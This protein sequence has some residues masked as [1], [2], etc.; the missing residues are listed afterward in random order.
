M[1]SRT[2]LGLLL[3]VALARPVAAQTE[4]G[5]A[6]E[7]VA[8]LS[9]PLHVARAITYQ[10]GESLEPFRAI[11]ELIR[12]SMTRPSLR[13]LLDHQL[14]KMLTPLASEE[15]RLFAARNLAIVGGDRSL[16]EVARLLNDEATVSLACL[17]L[18][19]YPR[20][21]ADEALRSALANTQGKARV[22][23]I[24][25][26][27]DRRDPGSI[28]VLSDLAGDSDPAV[29][30][31]AVVAL[32]KIGNPQSRKALDTLFQGDAHLESVRTLARLRTALQLADEGHRDAVPALEALLTPSTP[33]YVRRSALAALLKADQKGAPMRI[34]EVLRGHEAA[35]KPVAI[36]AVRDLRAKDASANFGGTVLPQ[37]PPEQQVWMIE[38]LAIRKDPAACDAIINALATSKDTNVRQSAAQA[39]G[40]IGEPT[41][42]RPLAKAL[43]ATTNSDEARVIVGSV[44]ALRE[45]KATDQAVLAEIKAAEDPARALLVSSLA[46]RRSPEVIAALFDEIDGSD[47]AS[48]KAA[49]RVMAKSVTSE[50][51][52]KLLT[53]Y[54]RL[55]NEKLQSEVETFIE[56]AVL[57]VDDPKVR[58]ESVRAVLAQTFQTPGRAGLV[59]LL[60]LCG[61]THSLNVAKRCL[62]DPEKP[63]RDSAVSALA[64][65][66]DAS[67]WDALFGVQ[68]LPREPRYRGIA[69]RGLVRLVSEQNAKPDAVLVERYRQLLEAARDENERKLVLGALGGAASPET[70]KLAV[71]ALN[72]PRVR[73]EAEAAIKRISEAI[74]DKHPEEVKLALDRL[75]RKR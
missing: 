33:I 7:T 9:L 8:E 64:E 18:S 61:D 37:L 20:G 23:I 55:R 41:F 51:L 67:A 29:A 27:G 13:K 65:W 52:F 70:L 56:Q 1:K 30:E 4:P 15:T 36:A 73:A 74:K 53:K 12:Q 16:P 14:G 44:A 3:L 6:G 34:V 32:G 57:T 19:T 47:A 26:L 24:N 60:P 45:G 43:A 46:A 69:M 49:F 21:A 72:Y 63:V 68:K 17:A 11:E 35:L 5:G 22:Q 2:F 28:K 54:A 71:G 40:Q 62:H 31:A 58:S 25:T 39:L 48:A 66:P 38:S 50:T 75:T 42:A 59:R 10:P